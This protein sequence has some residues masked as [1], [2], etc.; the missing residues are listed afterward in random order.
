MRFVKM[1]GAGNDY[2]VLEEKALT[3]PPGELAK[4]LSDRHFGIG[5]DGLI[6]VCPG[7]LADYEMRMYNPDGTRAQMCGN[8]IRCLGKYV[9][10]AGLVPGETF[11][12]ESAG[13]V[14]KL[15]Y[16]RE[17]RHVT[18][19][20]E[21]L[22][23]YLSV[24]MGTPRLGGEQVVAGYRLREVNMGNPHAVTFAE[25]LEDVPVEQAGPMIERGDPFPER[26]NVEFVQVLGRD[27]IRLRVW[28]RGTGETLACG[29]GACAAA[30]VC[31]ENG[32]TDGKITVKLSGGELELAWDG[33][34]TSM[35]LTGPAETVFEGTI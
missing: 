3:A 22:T 19:W 8:G 25:R 31:V 13:V 21:R 2:V 1:Q 27:L 4:A 15:Q 16:L 35:Y 23:A 17:A 5:S 6:L 9:W 12:V 33:K 30:A 18:P 7:K 14:H 10:D 20:G 24:D 29:T 34:G 28:E 26:T 11:T 32:L